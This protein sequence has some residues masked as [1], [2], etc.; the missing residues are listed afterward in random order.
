MTACPEFHVGCRLDRELVR[1][2]TYIIHNSVINLRRLSWIVWWARLHG[3]QEV[4]GWSPYRG[5]H[6]YL[7]YQASAC[8][9]DSLR[10]P[11][12][13]FLKR[14]WDFRLSRGVCSG[15]SQG[16]TEWLMSLIH[17]LYCIVSV[18]DLWPQ[19]RG[20]PPAVPMLLS[21]VGRNCLSL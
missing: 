8:L 6:F 11:N 21:M 9:M 1:P 10:L 19:V 3:N 13:P 14:C 20:G 2:P 16:K 15:L 7:N 18:G 5:N 17:V 12:L 4:P